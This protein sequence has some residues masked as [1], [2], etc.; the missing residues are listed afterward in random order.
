MRAAAERFAQVAHEAAHVGARAAFD[1]EAQQRHLAVQQV[2]D[3]DQV[4]GVDIDGARVDFHD[5]AARVR[6]HT[7]A[8]RRA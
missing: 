1:V 4:E 7:A 8:R 6:A 3:G 2:G 5:L